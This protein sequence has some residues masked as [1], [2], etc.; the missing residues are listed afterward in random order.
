MTYRELLRLYKKGELDEK[1]AA[2]VKAAIEQQEAIGEYLFDETEIPT[3]EGGEAADL[4]ETG[5][6]PEFVAV[7]QK[8][9]RKAFFKLG[10]SVCAV[11]LAGALLAVFVLPHVAD[12]FYY[13]P[14]EVV[15]EDTEDGGMET[16]RMS[17]D[18]AVWTEL[19]TPGSF[20][21]QAIVTPRGYGRYDFCIPQT[22]SVGNGFTT[23]GGS[24]V[25]NQ[26]TL[27]DPNI[28]RRPVGNAF[29]M[30]GGE[31]QGTFDSREAS[32][33]A[34]DK[35][36]ENTWYQGYVSLSEI[37]DYEDFT[38]WYEPLELEAYHPW[39]AVFDGV[40]SDYLG[41]ILGFYPYC[42]GYIMHWDEEAYP[43]LRTTGEDWD[44]MWTSEPAAREHFVS[45][46][47]YQLDHPEFSEMMGGPVLSQYETEQLLN[48]IGE[49]GLQVYGFSITARKAAFERLR[50][51]PHVNF[52]HTIPA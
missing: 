37:M 32:F 12:Q 44:E 23:L 50:Q 19:F 11:V 2:E 4:P 34:V 31:D 1:T 6:N 5:E 3:L 45:M 52:I 33:A 8:A 40:H 29:V 21:D 28:L 22:L 13:D 38:A 18:L 7:V 26:L 42:G 24:L 30:P 49:N 43:R 48:N 27:Y 25:R 46:L 39:C 14:T 41:S 35:L 20:R 9:I 17:L 47:R 10:A 36:E 51:D 15:G 16:D